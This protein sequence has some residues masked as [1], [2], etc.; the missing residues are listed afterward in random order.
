VRLSVVADVR[1]ADVTVG[2]LLLLLASFML[3]AFLN[4]LVSSQMNLSAVADVK[5]ADAAIAGIPATSDAQC[6]PCTG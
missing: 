3:L 4:L 5:D 1:D 6:N 2:G